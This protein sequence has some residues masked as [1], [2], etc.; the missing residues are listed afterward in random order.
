MCDTPNPC[1]VE[2]NEFLAF[3]ERKKLLLNY[4]PKSRRDLS[5]PKGIWKTRDQ[6]GVY[7]V[8]QRMDDGTYSVNETL[9]WSLR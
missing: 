4:D 2:S 6:Y 3:I 8:F 9:L 1:K 5:K 7:Y